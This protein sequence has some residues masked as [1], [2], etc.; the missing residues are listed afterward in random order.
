MYCVSYQTICIKLF[1]CIKKCSW[2]VWFAWAYCP[3]VTCISYQTILYFSF[4]IMIYFLFSIFGVLWRLWIGPFVFSMWLLKFIGW[5]FFLIYT[6]FTVVYWLYSILVWLLD[7]G[8]EDYLHYIPC[9]VN[10]VI[11]YFM[12]CN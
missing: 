7:E 8:K 3:K 4:F 11:I 2:I 12:H 6:N 5:L 9:V 1:G 10:G